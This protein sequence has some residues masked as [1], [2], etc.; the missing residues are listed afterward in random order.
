MNCPRCGSRQEDTAKF[1]N[2]CSAPLTSPEKTYAVTHDIV[3][4]GQMAFGAGEI[5]VVEAI[6]ANPQQP[7]YKYVVTSRTLQKK[8][9]LSNGD[10]TEVVQQPAPAVPPPAPPAQVPAPPIAPPVSSRKQV[11]A[12]GVMRAGA[13]PPVMAKGSPALITPPPGITRQPAIPSRVRR[14]W[15]SFRDWWAVQSGRT[16][17]IT[18]GVTAAIVLIAAIVGAVVSDKGSESGTATTETTTQESSESA[19]LNAA[20]EAPNFAETADDFISID[21]VQ[22]GQELTAQPSVIAGTAKLECTITLNGQPVGIVPETKQFMPTV[23]IAEGPNTLAFV[24][25]DANGKTYNKNITI[26]GTL[27]ME[28]YKAVSPPLVAYVELNKN[29]NAYAGTRCKLNGQVVQAMVEGSTTVL[30]V[31]VTNKGYGFWDDTVYVTLDGTTPAVDG[32][33][34]WVYG[35]ITGGKTYESTA[36]WNITIPAVDAK[37]VDVVG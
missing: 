12:P 18:I 22:N 25:T 34:V 17:L 30:R 26:T 33:M 15:E 11:Q 28:T 31:N 16:K 3:V 1:C 23:N 24:V 37:Y 19:K 10:L 7:E 29:P 27:A 2:N 5:V 20:K 6:S 35:M 4:G 13:K 36:G 8:F 21:N 14:S 9:Q 32:S